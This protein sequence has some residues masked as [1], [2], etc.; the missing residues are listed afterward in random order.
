MVLVVKNLPASSRDVRDVGSA[1]KSGRSPGGGHCLSLERFFTGCAFGL[2]N[3]LSS[4]ISRANNSLTSIKSL[5][6]YHL[7]NDAFK[8]WC[9][10]GLLRVP[11]TIGRLN[12]LILKE[13]NPECSLEGVMLKLKLQYFGHLI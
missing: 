8:L 13:I 1:S 2:Y 12:Q 10:R 7:S 6:K 11:W 4:A 3:C 5:L 9:W